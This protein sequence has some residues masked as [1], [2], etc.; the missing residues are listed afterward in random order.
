ME[1]TPEA[2]VIPGF[3]AINPGRWSGSGRAEIVRGPLAGKA[4]LPDLT[5]WKR[6]IW[7][8][9]REAAARRGIAIPSERA[10]PPGWV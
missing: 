9:T 8:L 4:T 5:D 2:L 7:L 10:E 1:P 6:E 3:V